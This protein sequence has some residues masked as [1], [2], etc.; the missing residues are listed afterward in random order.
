MS[1]YI[2]ST[3]RISVA[4]TATLTMLSSTAI[5]AASFDCAKAS[6]RI[7]KAICA[8][9]KVSD[10]D[11]KLAEIYS[12][13]VLQSSDVESEKLA[14]RSWLKETRNQCQDEACLESAYQQR[15]N[16]LRA[17]LPVEKSEAVAKADSVNSEVATAGAAAEEEKKQALDAAEDEKRK[18]EQAAVEL[19][20]KQA[21]DAAAVTAIAKKKADDVAFWTNVK[22]VAALCIFVA[23]I[24][25]AL[26]QRKRR[27]AGTQTDADRSNDLNKSIG[28]ILQESVK[29]V[30]EGAKTS[31]SD[32]TAPD[33]ESV[34]KSPKTS[35]PI[36]YLITQFKQLGT[37]Q[38][39]MVALLLLL[40]LTWP[41]LLFFVVIFGLI[42][43][44]LKK[45]LKPM[46]ALGFGAVALVATIIVGGIVNKDMKTGNPTSIADAFE[47]LPSE[48]KRTSCLLF[49]SGATEIVGAKVSGA[50]SVPILASYDRLMSAYPSAAR[51]YVMFMLN[52]VDA[53]AISSFPM[54]LKGGS[55]AFTE[56]MLGACLRMNN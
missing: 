31:N 49:A 1:K 26:V 25:Y 36:Q 51:S 18:A 11:S 28:S 56:L 47:K 53:K 2:T 5:Q 23:M 14:Q 9:P 19:S 10:L 39:V 40:S 30:Q 55:G 12:A 3:L 20:K 22:G 43:L 15:I 24:F 27:K 8:S 6:S 54:Y 50:S 52:G 17:L 42:F 37:F 4:F 34:D 38:K 45:K 16:S 13:V 32:A 41:G 48:E 29:Q 33:G 44:V 46:K 21:D 35:G 7:D